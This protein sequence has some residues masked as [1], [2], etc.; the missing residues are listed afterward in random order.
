[1]RMII[2]SVLLLLISCK[3]SNKEEKEINFL[4]LFDLENYNPMDCQKL[5]KNI[6]WQRLE[7]ESLTNQDYCNVHHQDS[8][9]TTYYYSP[10]GSQNFLEII[11]YQ[12]KVLEYNNSLINQSIQA[13]IEYFDE[14]LWISYIGKSIPNLKDK[15]KLKSPEKKEIIKAYYSLL[16]VNTTNEYGW[17]C[18]YST[19]GMLTSKR[20]AILKLVKHEKREILKNLLLHPNIQ[21]QIYAADAIIFFDYQF[22]R[23]IKN[24]EAKLRKYIPELSSEEISQNPFIQELKNKIMSPEEKRLIENLKNSDE[25]IIT[26]G[27]S[28]SYKLYKNTTKELLSKESVTEIIDNYEYYLKFIE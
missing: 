10:K 6:S 3:E 1:M 28:G 20:Q 26:C 19:V 7:E 22:Q 13:K 8:L 27:N 16:G 25:T 14:K 21:I 11:S 5:L 2:I 18:E 15:F 4:N 24:Y 12:N 9:L 17:I 23:E